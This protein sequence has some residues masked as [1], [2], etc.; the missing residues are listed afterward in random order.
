[1]VKKICPSAKVARR[2]EGKMQDIL[3]VARELL[4]RKGVEGL[5][6]EAVAEQLSLTK[7]AVFHYFDSKAALVFAVALGEFEDMAHRIHAATVEAPDGASALE[8]V[9]R[10]TVLHFHGRI[11]AFR[12][13]LHGLQMDESVAFIRPEH[14]ARLRPL[15]DLSYGPAAQKLADDMRAGRIPRHV[16]PRRLVFSAFL[17][18][19]G[20]LS[21]KAMVERLNDP[22]GYSDEALVKELCA[23]F[24]AV[25]EKGTP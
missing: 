12:V 24:R 13:V 17:A 15:N 20:L 8:A 9:I 19:F 5:T 10:G 14:L 6:F 1:M 4:M 18:A 22:L 7:P 25:V 2:R 11:D 16:N 21:M 3:K 23:A